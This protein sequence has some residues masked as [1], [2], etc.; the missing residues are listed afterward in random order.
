LNLML[1]PRWKKI[2]YDV[3]EDKFRTLLVVLS[4]SLGIIGVGVIGQT[5]YI[6]SEGMEKGYKQANPANVVISLGSFGPSLIHKA[7]RIKE[8]KVAAGKAVFPV[9]F[10]KKKIAGADNNSHWN[11]AVLF[12]LDFQHMPMDRFY[13][14]KGSGDPKRGEVLVEETSLAH[15]Q[16]KVG[17][18]I[19]IETSDGKK[20]LMKISGTVHD[21]GKM[22]AI[23]SNEMYM[24]IPLSHLREIANTNQMNTLAIVV[25]KHNARIR[26][27]QETASKIRS[28][29]KKSGIPVY[30]TVI[31][32]KGR[33]WAY[34][35]VHSMILIFNKFGILILLASIGLVINTVMSLL[36]GQLKQIGIMQVIGA[37]PNQLFAMYMATVLFYSF[38]SLCI[39]IPA[40]IWGARYLTGN[41]MEL[42]NF[43]SANIGLSIKV[44]YSQIFIGMIV[45]LLVSFY[46]IYKGSRISV[47]EAIQGAEEIQSLRGIPFLKW[48]CFVSAPQILAF[49]NAF[50]KKGRLALTLCTLTLTGTTIISVASIYASMQ[51]TKEQSLQYTKYDYQLEL[52][53]PV[54]A[55]KLETVIQ[56]VKGVKKAE[57]WG[58]VSGAYSQRNGLKSGDITIIA[59]KTATKMIYPKIVEGTWLTAKDKNSIVLDT[60]ILR[61]DPTVKVGDTLNFIINNKRKPLKIAGYARKAAGEVLSYINPETLKSFNLDDSNTLIN[62]T[63]KSPSW[64]DKEKIAREIKEQ[65]NAEGIN[66]AKIKSTKD[67]QLG[68]EIRFNIEL[69]L[70]SVF[71]VLITCVAV[72]GLMG[73]ISLNVLERKREIG[74][75]RSIGATD[76]SLFFLVVSESLVIGAAGWAGAVLLSF[77]I[78]RSLSNEVGY[79]LFQTPLDFHYSYSSIWEWFIL[80][81]FI[82]IAASFIPAWNVAK[83]EIREVLAYE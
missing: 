6:L 57:F 82:A 73:N 37:T 12:A 40:S 70:L 64:Q 61:T 72:V 80:S 62:F 2:L 65:L 5:N 48:P 30:S 14:S 32:E 42:L 13:A 11:N 74:I 79:S 58:M 66:V 67:I 21:P 75:L 31:A 1:S 59:P 46:P 44:L 34:D 27:F 49:R 16:L 77:P 28:L 3:W 18:F 63:V 26:G 71:A 78:S 7:K 22:T 52:K 20:H 83:T 43:S 68:L 50:R 56:R 24:F 15:F 47:R 17:D 33:H 8:V 39:G 41:S 23:L 54:G 38:L 60:N 36:K 69:M 53:R 76:K 29:A 35:I 25:D 51:K 81:C 45:P 4:I 55:K 19:W 9:Q 10:Q